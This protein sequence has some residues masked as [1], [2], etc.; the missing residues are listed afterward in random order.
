MSL[1]KNHST[2]REESGAGNWADGMESL[3][4]KIE[5][6]Q[7]IP[8]KRVGK[9]IYCDCS[10]KPLSSEHII[11]YGLNGPWILD[12]ASCPR[13]RDITSKFEL[14]VLHKS[15]L[16]TRTA[17]NLQTRRKQNRPSKLSLSVEKDDG[18]KEVIQLP[19]D[20]Y[21]GTV[22]FLI[23]DM[24]AYLTGKHYAKGVNVKES[25][26]MKVSGPPIEVLAK[27]Y[28]LK[29][30]SF[31]YTTYGNTFEQMLAK[32]GLGFA[33][34]QFGL[35]SFDDIYVRP[36]ILGQKD[37]AGM[38]IG[39]AK[40]AILE[41]DGLHIVKLLYHKGDVIARIRLFA[42]YEV[43]EYLVVVGRLKKQIQGQIHQNEYTISYVI[44]D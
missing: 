36:T 19:V 3:S 37:D 9:C 14:Q 6:L 42:M 18:S 21:I 17:M 8:H 22:T 23:E 40:D 4:G 31:P 41:R 24:P 33:V 32:I 16:V 2:D 30:I 1:T 34:G 25:I 7:K 12:E 10:D 29:S 39:S 28:G 11:P 38:W 44:N 43:P 13:C 15:L 27:K 26:L 35:D 20:E 5:M